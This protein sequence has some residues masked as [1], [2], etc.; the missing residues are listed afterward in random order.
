M[1]R[2]ESRNP[3]TG[4]VVGYV[5]ITPVETIDGIVA[6]ARAALPAW[7]DLEAEERGR[8]LIEA[9][10]CLAEGAET[11]GRQLSDEMGKP[12]GAAIAEVRRC[13][14]EMSHKV[15]EVI[16]AIRPDEL[17]EGT[18]RSTIYHD[19]LGV[20]AAIMPWNYPMSMLQWM[21]VPALV[22]GNTVVLKPSEETPLTGQAY[23]DALNSVLPAGVLQVVHGA[24]EQGK[25]LVLADVDLIAFTGSRSAGKHIL[26]AAADGLKRVI[27]ELGG[28]D[29]LIV[30]ADANVARAARFAA[31][32]SFDNAG[33]ACV[34]TERIYV[35]ESI[36]AEF[37]AR[38]ADH[39]EATVLGDPTEDPDLGPLVNQQQ[40]DHVMRQIHDAAS[41]G[42]RV[43]TGGKAGEG[44]YIPPTVL[45]ET[46]E[47]MEIMRHETFG[48]VACV[49]TFRD[50]D[51]AVRRANQGPYGLGAVVFGSDERAAG[52]A[53]R[54]DAGMIGVNQA[55]YGTSGTPWVGAKESGYGFHGSRDGHR[56]FTQ[57][58]VLSRKV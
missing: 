45:A 44:L 30:L 9:A 7:H 42:A 32:N 36:A 16:D 22:A 2:L 35:H 18:R 11:L 17:S 4:E 23:A 43:L 58:R 50:E 51:E 10:E 39:A 57:T 52:V 49:S 20:C 47:E 12:V 13:G 8:L 28:K 15:A 48:P 21:L 1:P 34:S 31:A 40:F 25:R 37:E 19:P 33:Q 38:L 54:L 55:I 41:K 24:E 5:E 53:R 29:A 26:R 56:Q 3:A 46:T 14:T 27:L 6:R